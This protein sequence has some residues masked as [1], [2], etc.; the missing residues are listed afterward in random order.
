M[1]TILK[2]LSTP[3]QIENHVID[4]MKW[5]MVT[6]KREEPDQ[7]LIMEMSFPENYTNFQK[8]RLVV[9]FHG[10]H[11]VDIIHTPLFSKTA[12]YIQHHFGGTIHKS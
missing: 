2:N 11:V 6:T 12:Q 10:A 3:D 8:E 4:A 1:D 9:K 5:P 7:T